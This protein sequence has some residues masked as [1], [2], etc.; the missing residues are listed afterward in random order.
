MMMNISAN[1]SDIL[2]SDEDDS[3]AITLTI[4]P[5]YPIRLS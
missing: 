1:R 4:H 3:L 2:K 5:A